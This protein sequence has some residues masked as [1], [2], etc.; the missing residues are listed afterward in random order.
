MAPET[1]NSDPV[2]FDFDAGLGEDDLVAALARRLEPRWGLQR[3]RERRHHLT[4]FDTFDWRLWNQGATLRWRRDPPELIWREVSGLLRHRLALTDPSRKGVADETTAA[5]GLSVAEDSAVGQPAEPG[6]A[7]AAE[8]EPGKPFLPSDLPAGPLR[9]D[10]ERAAWVR[11]LLPRVTVRR[12]RRLLRVLDDNQK[13]VVRLV[14]EHRRAADPDRP[15][16]SAEVAPVLRVVA[17]KGYDQQFQSVL[18]ALAEEPLLAPARGDELTSAVTAL[19]RWPGDYSSKIQLKLDP[20][21]R[22]DRALKGVL[23]SLLR[24]ME[25]NEDGIRKALDPEFLHDFRVAVRRSR[26]ALGQVKGIF[27]Q[28][29]VEHFK[30]ELKWLGQATGPKRD[31]DVYSMQLPE[32]RQQ[33]PD[34][35]GEALAPLR[36]YLDRHSAEEQENLE[37]ILAG[38]RYRH[39]LEEWRQFLEQPVPAS[40]ELANARRPLLEVASE[41][42]WKMWRRVF[43]RGRAIDDE[44]PAEALHSLRIDCKKLRYLLEFFRGLYTEEDVARLIKRLKKLQDNLGDFNDLEVQQETLQSFAVGMEKEGLAPVETILAMGRLVERMAQGQ[45]RE[46]ERFDKRFRRFTSKGNRRRFRELFRPEAREEAS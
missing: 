34:S 28:P 17:V 38:D 41:R 43:R 33:L 46:R 36:T 19:G 5:A 9:E 16:R 2:F 7:P 15:R 27:P 29:V 35:A 25:V 13:T 45:V 6:E 37:E 22:A 39:F 44:T 23:L 1:V 20:K 40:T 18:G 32:Y 26:A 8:L 14:L 11:C 3:E 42:I 31:L 21:E 12:R 24:S 10:L 4:Y 30:T